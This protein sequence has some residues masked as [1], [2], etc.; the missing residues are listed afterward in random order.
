MRKNLLVI[1]FALSI[2]TISLSPL[3]VEASIIN[4]SNM[5]LVN[6]DIYSSGFS[7]FAGSFEF[8]DS[9]GNA[10]DE[11]GN[12]SISGINTGFFETSNDFTPSS[13]SDA[14]SFLLNATITDG[15][16]TN[17]T[18]EITGA[19][20]GYGSDNSSL[21][22]SGILTD[23]S[24]DGSNLEF[25]FDVTDGFLSTLYGDLGGLI[26]ST[27]GFSSFA[28]DYSDNYY[29]AD[30]KSVVK[31]SEP[32]TILL[33]LLGLSSVFCSRRYSSKTIISKNNGTKK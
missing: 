1:F 16:L 9:D 31:V 20:N 22:L 2:G 23:F 30:T 32:E 15:L 3:T 17:G 14:G 12:L 18:L 28:T 13:F 26:I 8:T 21:L 11:S 5:I 25:I 4:A 33:M 24:I 19:V 29:T 27:S 10:E 6:P 7:G